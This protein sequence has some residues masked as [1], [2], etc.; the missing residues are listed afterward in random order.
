MQVQVFVNNAFQENTYVVSNPT[1]HQALLIDPGMSNDREWQQVKDYLEGQHLQLQHI[2]LTH[3][4]IDHLMGTGYLAEW[5]DVPVSGPL[6]D[7]LRL[8]SHEQQFRLFGLSCQHPV[9]TV[10]NN[11][12]EGDTLLFGNSLIQVLD[13]PGHSYHGLCYY[14]PEQKLLFTGDVLFYCS[15]GRSDFGPSMGCD[16]EA[17]VQGIQTKLMALPADTKVY[18]GHGPATSIGQET[19]YNPYF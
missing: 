7:D 19:M 5:C 14:F 10:K 9:G 3:C 18:P 4:H 15:I 1:T 11:V 17:L 12:N 16:G 13:I 2:L 8:P 6:E